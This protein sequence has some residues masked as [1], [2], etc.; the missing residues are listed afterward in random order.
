MPATSGQVGLAT[1]AL[2]GL[3]GTGVVLVLSAGSRTFLVRASVLGGVWLTG[4]VAG[5]SAWRIHRGMTEPRTWR[6]AA[7]SFAAG[8]AVGVITLLVIGAIAE[9]ATVVVL[10]HSGFV[11]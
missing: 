5:L 1:G 3:G 4:V 8:A 10:E 7:S 2:L 6:S 11:W 9:V